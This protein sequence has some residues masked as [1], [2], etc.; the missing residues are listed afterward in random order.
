MGVVH[1]ME[2]SLFFWLSQIPVSHRMPLLCRG[3]VIMNQDWLVLYLLGLKS[4]VIAWNEMPEI[5]WRHMKYA[6]FNNELHFSQSHPTGMSYCRKSPFSRPSRIV[7]SRTVGKQMWT[8][9]KMLFYGCRH[10]RFEVSRQMSIL[11]YARI[12]GREKSLNVSSD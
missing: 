10:F 5:C 12:Q 3:V 11:A 4:F 9:Y 6:C 1:C 8:I 2:H 7:V